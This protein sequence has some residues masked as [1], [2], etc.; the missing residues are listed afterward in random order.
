MICPAMFQETVDGCGD[1]ALAQ[2]PPLVFSKEID[3]VQASSPRG[4]VVC[5]MTPD[6][7]HELL[8]FRLQDE[9]EMRGVIFRKLFAPLPFSS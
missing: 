3:L 1:H 8:G 2:P 7:A 6:E 5:G 9:N 4:I